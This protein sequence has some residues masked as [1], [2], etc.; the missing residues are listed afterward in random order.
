MYLLNVTEVNISVQMLWYNLP[1]GTISGSLPSVI[2]KITFLYPFEYRNIHMTSS[3]S[4]TW[5]RFPE[6]HSYQRSIPDSS[7]LCLHKP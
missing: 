1:I 7:H 3:A 6:Q 2:W 4:K 5:C